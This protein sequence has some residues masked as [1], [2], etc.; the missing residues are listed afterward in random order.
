MAGALVIWSNRGRGSSAP[1]GIIAHRPLR[2]PERLLVPVTI[3]TAKWLFSVC[4]MASSF[5]SFPYRD[6]LRMAKLVTTG[7]P[8]SSV[9]EMARIFG[10]TPDVVSK[11]VRIA[12]RTL[13]RRRERLK[14]DESERVLR[15]G[16]LLHL[17]EDVFEDRRSAIKWFLRPLQNLGGSSPLHLCSTEFGAR[18]V[19]QALGRIEHGVFS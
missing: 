4:H 17:A 12:P 5:A 11:I 16:R 18:E 7:L 6:N 2:L 19:E 15:V 10:L 1:A 9:A 13:A 3:D 14:A 8:S